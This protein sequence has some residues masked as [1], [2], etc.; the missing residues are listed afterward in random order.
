M[1][2]KFERLPNFCFR[3]GLLDHVTGRCKFGVPAT[4]T[5]HYGVSARIYGPWL[6]AEVASSLI[7]AHTPEGKEDEQSFPKNWKVNKEDYAQNKQLL[8]EAKKSEDQVDR[9]NE[10]PIEELSVACEMC[11]ELEALNL[12]LN[13]Q[14][15]GDFNTVRVAILH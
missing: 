9:G 10:R 14:F 3:C 15:S 2:F 13:W 1:Q 5:S 4:L 6:K 12:T 8:L 7:F 11:N